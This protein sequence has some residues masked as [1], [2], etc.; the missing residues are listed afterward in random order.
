M[1]AE[2]KE[3]LMDLYKDVDRYLKEVTKHS[4]LGKVR[5][6]LIDLQEEVEKELRQIAWEEFREKHKL[7]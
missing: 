2:K 1:D 4:G 3:F 6:R 7:E 5:N